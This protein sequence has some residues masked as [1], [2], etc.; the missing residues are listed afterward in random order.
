LYIAEVL[1]IF[2]FKPRISFAASMMF[3]GNRGLATKKSTPAIFASASYASKA[4]VPENI[5]IVG[6]TPDES[7]SFNFFT[8]SR[9]VISGKSQ[10]I[11]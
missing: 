11:K 6:L 7:I 9:L 2:F 5:A 1:S 8:K 10:P 4:L 3:D